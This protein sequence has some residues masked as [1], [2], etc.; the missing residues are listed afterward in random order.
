MVAPDT[1]VYAI[2]DLHGR[3]D[4]LRKMLERILSD[5]RHLD[6]GRRC[7][8]V[9]LGDYIDRGDHSRQVLEDLMVLTKDLS[10]GII[11]LRGNH[12]EAL[13]AFLRSPARES[14]WLDHGAS[15]TLAD[16]GVAAPTRAPSERDLVALRDAVEA[17]MGDHVKF[18]RGLPSHAVS[19]DVIFAHA[20]LDPDDADTL[21]NEA[22]MMW[23][24]P[25]AC[26]SWPVPG[27]LL[28]HGHHDAP[29]PVDR[30]GR[31]CV[32]TGAY[33]SGRLTAVRLDG[34]RTFLTVA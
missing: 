34:S 30:P 4:L 27:K 26:G 19:G 16:Y 6:D 28:V 10:D 13:L 1:R 7:R 9:F 8:I 24:C 25:E 15:Q 2:G 17:A 11:A 32:D 33:H 12:E 23:G 20:G 29:E 21:T 18:L 3:Q 22:A 5:Q 31:I 14:A